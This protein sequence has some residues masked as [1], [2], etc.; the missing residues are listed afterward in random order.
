MT[1]PLSLIRDW[2]A[3]ELATD[4]G[5]SGA[6]VV[7]G[8]PLWGDDFVDHFERYCAPSLL[9]NDLGDCEIVLFVDGPTEQRLQGSPLPVRLI[10]LPEPIVEALYREPG[11]KYPLLAAAHNLLIHKAAGIGAGFHMTVADTVYSENYFANL[12]RLAERHDAIS[13]TGFAIKDWSGLP[14]IDA[15]RVD[16]AALA[17]SA[18]ALGAIGW[19]HLNPQWASW[20]MD[21]ITDFREMPNSYYIHWRGQRSVRIHCAHQSAA[22]IGPE[23]CMKVTPNYAGTIDSELPRYMAGD[24]YTPTLTDDMVFVCISME[25]PPVP[26]V[27]FDAFAAE[28]WRFIGGNREFL[29]YF[30]TPV[31]VPAPLDERAPSEAELDA[32]MG[33]LM[34][35][36]GAC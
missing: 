2:H 19:E 3:R 16:G 8:S 13:H 27:S 6:R 25:A 34:Q 18:E 33:Q 23:R 20:T 15:L 9:A 22:W 28:M 10:R 14:A 4:Y 7:T 29:P 11:H 24:T 32:R 12:A 31:H 5:L 21:G 30:R 26:R 17:L 1:D 36:L 35:R